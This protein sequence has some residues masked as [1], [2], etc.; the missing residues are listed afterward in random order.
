[1]PKQ[2][3]ISSESIL[4]R[5]EKERVVALHA[6]GVLDTPQEE[7]FDRITTMAQILFNVPIA[8]VSLVDSERQWFKSCAGIIDT[9][10]TPRNVSFCSHAILDDTIMLIEDA[11]KDPR[12]V[13]N[14][15]VTGPPHMRFYAGRPIK[16]PNNQKIGTLCI[17]DTKPRTLS[18]TDRKILNDLA[19]WTES[20]FNT[21]DLNNKL[22]K[23]NLEL[24]DS[25]KTKE[26]LV[27]MISHD[28]KN[29]LSPI[30]MCSEML[31]SHIPGPLNEKQQQM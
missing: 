25:I 15:L 18:M 8:L 22:K 30:K 4:I 7:R 11:T 6:L 23:S 13:N 19:T 21:V 31:E 20:E 16:G 27:A 24:Q 17:I 29:P 12:F 28:L 1:M 26:E 14:S 3:N 9:R 5:N 10:E 2:C